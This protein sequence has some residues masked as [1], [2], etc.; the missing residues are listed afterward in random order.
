MKINENIKA[1][2]RCPYCGDVIEE[3]M[4]P[5]KLEME[6]NKTRIDKNDCLKGDHHVQLWIGLPVVFSV[7][8]MNH[9]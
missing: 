8:N 9:V 7:I 6:Y 3:S 5:C 1:V 4:D 2:A